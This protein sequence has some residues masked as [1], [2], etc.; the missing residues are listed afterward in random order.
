M[1]IYRS[2]DM[3]FEFLIEIGQ[4]LIKLDGVGLDALIIG[5]VVLRLINLRVQ[6]CSKLTA[7]AHEKA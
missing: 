2:L 5:F 1:M 7:R 4:S 3:I 6:M